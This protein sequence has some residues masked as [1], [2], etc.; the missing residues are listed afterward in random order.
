MR[1]GISFIVL[2]RTLLRIFLFTTEMSSLTNRIIRH[3]LV[4]VV[5]LILLRIWVEI[6]IKVILIEAKYRR[7]MIMVIKAKYDRTIKKWEGLIWICQFRINRICCVRVSSI[8]FRKKIVNIVFMIR[9][10]MI[11]KLAK[12][13]MILVFS[14]RNSANLIKR[15][16]SNFRIRRSGITST[17]RSMNSY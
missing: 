5:T 3:W 6:R 17:K 10:R 8:L 2:S 7:T 16:I 4:K 15:V 13:L 14:L 1:M 11:I 9:C 12:Y